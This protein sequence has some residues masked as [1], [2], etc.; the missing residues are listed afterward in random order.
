MPNDDGAVDLMESN[1]D[2]HNNVMAVHHTALND[3]YVWAI[4]SAGIAYELRR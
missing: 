1:V 3:K 4:K 2:E